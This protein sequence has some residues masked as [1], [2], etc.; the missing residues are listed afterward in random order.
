MNYMEMNEN[1][2][3][4]NERVWLWGPIPFGRS[5]RGMANNFSFS[6]VELLNAKSHHDTF[7]YYGRK[8]IE[9]QSL[10]T[11]EFGP[12]ESNSVDVDIL[13]VGVVSSFFGGKTLNCR[14]YSLW[15]RCR[16]HRLFFFL[17][18]N[19]PS[20]HSN[21][22]THSLQGTKRNSSHSSIFTKKKQNKKKSKRK[23]MRKN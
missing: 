21:I 2:C 10:N 18:F 5:V 15:F 20:T 3:T 22:H 14:F 11:C 4:S 13:L 6:C 12:F 23:M 7:A 19:Q 16:H 8:I 9:Q 1:E 17:V